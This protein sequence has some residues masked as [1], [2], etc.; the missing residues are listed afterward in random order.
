MS[1]HQENLFGSSRSL[2]FTR[3]IRCVGWLIL[4][5]AVVVAIMNFGLPLGLIAYSG[6]T[7]LGAYLIFLMLLYI[8][9]K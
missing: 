2:L 7:S 1:R 6:Y 8:E 5:F 3:C 4:F 9:R